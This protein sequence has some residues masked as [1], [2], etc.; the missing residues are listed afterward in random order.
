MVI[1]RNRLLCLSFLIVAALCMAV[2]A[3]AQT[4]IRIR[5]GGK[6]NDTITIDETSNPPMITTSEGVTLKSAPGALV[7]LGN[8]QYEIL[9]AGDAFYH[10][11]ARNGVDTITVFDGPGNSLYWLGGGA[12][13]DTI[14]VYDGP[15]DDEYKVEGKS[16]TD[17]IELY[18][19]SGDGNDYYYA[20]GSKGD[21]QFTLVDGPGDDFYKFK[22]KLGA[23]L[24]FTDAPGDVDEIQVRGFIFP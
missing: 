2:P 11:K 12:D 16:G 13:D 8:G 23:T 4:R 6:A 9:V 18:D 15:G 21:D 19:D 1:Y 20:K 22:A 7:D 3:D 24:D 5:A 14:I 17:V 10:L